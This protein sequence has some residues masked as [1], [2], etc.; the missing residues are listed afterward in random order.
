MGNN[1]TDSAGTKGNLNIEQQSRVLEQTAYR[2]NPA[3]QMG[4]V[5]RV[6]ANGMT[7]DP[8]GPPPAASPFVVQ[9]EP[10]KKGQTTVVRALEPIFQASIEAAGQQGVVHSEKMRTNEGTPD[11]ATDQIPN[12]MIRHGQGMDDVEEVEAWTDLKVRSVLDIQLARGYGLWEWSDY[13]YTLLYGYSANIHRSNLSLYPVAAHP[14]IRWGKAFGSSYAALED[15]PNGDVP[16]VELAEALQYETQRNTMT[17]VEIGGRSYSGV[18]ACS[19]GL[20]T[21]WR[22]ALH[23]E[24]R[25]IGVRGDKNEMHDTRI[26]VWSDILFI[27]TGLA[28]ITPRKFSELTTTTDGEGTTARTIMDFAS[29]SN[30]D[31]PVEIGGAAA[32][33]IG[34]M[35]GGGAVRINNGSP[36]KTKYD[37]SEE[38]EERL[39]F[40]TGRVRGAKRFDR[41]LNSDGTVLNNTSFLH[42]A[43]RYKHSS[44]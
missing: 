37:K 8:E 41:K 29:L 16:S 22:M 12:Y 31:I 23:D 2:A 26:G 32:F 34:F 3:F 44:E 28:P 24:W 40:W 7:A 39:A 30:E 38:Y 19:Y 43:R 25:D 4:L 21:K 18:Y 6:D 17:R 35:L 15:N 33:D 42:I 11:F 20:W 1:V 10:S 27:A 13:W 14:N 5:S 9:S 36:M